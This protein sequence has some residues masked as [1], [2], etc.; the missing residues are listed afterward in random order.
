MAGV[1]ARPTIGLARATPRGTSIAVHLC[2]DGVDRLV[3]DLRDAHP[4]VLLANAVGHGWP[5]D[6]TLDLVHVPFGTHA[7][8][9]TTDRAFYRPLQALE[10]P[11]GTRVSAGIAHE[12]QPIED[13]RTILGIVEELL[14]REV[15][16]AACC[17]SG[18]RVL[19][20]MA[21]LCA[22]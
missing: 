14:G 9:P 21:A 8:P 18:P 16:V 3:P 4:L 15:V 1:L 11:P 22:S 6:S 2:L 5:A 12:G 7:R 19:D 10:V 13:Q 17:G 20:R